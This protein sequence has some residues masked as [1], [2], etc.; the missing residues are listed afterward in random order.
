MPF[1]LLLGTQ[2]SSTTTE[3]F[4]HSPLLS[5]RTRS[6]K[7]PMP[8]VMTTP[9]FWNSSLIQLSQVRVDDQVILASHV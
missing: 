9:H 8:S 7:R 3:R 1:T 4:I 6:P 5:T 2:T